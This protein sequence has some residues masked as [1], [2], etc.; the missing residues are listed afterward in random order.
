MRFRRRLVALRLRLT[1][2]LRLRG[3]AIV[4]ATHIKPR[5]PIRVGQEKKPEP[6]RLSQSAG[7]WYS[8]NICRW[9]VC[10][11]AAPGRGPGPRGVGLSP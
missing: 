2:D 3:L 7:L 1:S 8:R 6:L 10:M 5:L 11:S 4:L 9:Y